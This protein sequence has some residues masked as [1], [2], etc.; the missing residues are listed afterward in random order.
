MTSSRIPDP[1]LRAALAP[2]ALCE[3][4]EHRTLLTADPVAFGGKQRAIYTDADGGTVVIS[5]KGPGTGIVEFAADS[6]ADA[7]VVTLNGTTAASA[8]SVKGDTSFGKLVVNG[9]LKSVSGKTL[10]FAGDV[11]VTG[12]LPKVQ[13]RSAFNSTIT[14]G[15]T[16]P[17]SLTLGGAT[18]VS[19]AVTG[20][21][22]SIKVG[23]WADADETPD[24]I[25][26]TNVASLTAK[27]DFSAD[28]AAGTIG[29]L[30]VSGAIHGSEI[31]GTVNVG[32]VSA[33]A[34]R[35][36][37]VF[38]GIRADVSVLPSATGD[39]S[40]GVAAIKSITLTNKL[41]STFAGSIVAA[42]T[43]GKL[44]VGPIATF[45]GF[46]EFGVAADRIDSFSGSTNLRGAFK[47]PTQDPPTTAVS[48][49]D[50]VL[51]VL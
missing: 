6:P 12:G 11:T 50:F 29:K 17:L 4:L 5:L 14:I 34:L 15:Q 30:S 10:D 42:P 1:R 2:L 31:R 46:F 7:A 33:A 49:D 39:F 51:R 43:I 44:S 26:A 32:T 47:L 18:D 25:A 20:D 41:P 35:N 3:R 19:L 21:V 37:I 48:E 8:L 36:S 27:G 23:T 38:A 28:I 13:I 24:R 16:A 40:N 45:N 9:G 22:K